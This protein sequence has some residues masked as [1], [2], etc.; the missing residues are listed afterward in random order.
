MTIN[1][2]L[3]PLVLPV[4]TR[5]EVTIEEF[6]CGLIL[7]YH[8]VV[9]LYRYHEECVDIEPYGDQN[10]ERVTPVTIEPIWAK[11]IL[12]PDSKPRDGI[13]IL[14]MIEDEN[15]FHNMIIELHEAEHDL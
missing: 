6:D 8:E 13:N 15:K 10:V 5:Y 1:S 14:P 4:A 7:G 3:T 2:V 9:V 11:V 12:D